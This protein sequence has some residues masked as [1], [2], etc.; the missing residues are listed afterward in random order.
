MHQ[1][2]GLSHQIAGKPII[3]YQAYVTSRN[4]GMCNSQRKRMA[5][6]GAEDIEKTCRESARA[7]GYP[8]PRDQQLRITAHLNCV[9]IF[10]LNAGYRA[11]LN[12]SLSVC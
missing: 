10:L 9:D 5:T 8:T 11:Q 3:T 6:F 4:S 7:L 1:E 12:V 2:T